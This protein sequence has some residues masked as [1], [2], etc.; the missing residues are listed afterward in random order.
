[1]SPRKPRQGGRGCCPP[2]AA[3]CPYLPVLPVAEYPVPIGRVDLHRGLAD[4][5]D[6]ALLVLAA[7]RPHPA[8]HLG[9][10]KVGRGRDRARWGTQ[11]GIGNREGMEIG[12][13][14]DREPGEG[15]REGVRGEGRTGNMEMGIGGDG[16]G[17]GGGNWGQGGDVGGN[18]G[19]PGGILG[20]LG[21]NRGVPGGGFRAPSP[22]PSSLP[23]P[24]PIPPTPHP[25]PLH[26]PP[27]DPW[28]RGLAA[29]S[30]PA[31]A[32]SWPYWEKE[33]GVR[34]GPGGVRT[35]PNRAGTRG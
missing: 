1:M 30:A 9:E 13:R 11:R 32:A 14:M 25:T 8:V 4:H 26:S 24:P 6:A 35:T 7:E 21:G 33:R 34:G 10:E 27:R 3:P 19:V 18:Q 22:A 2:P 31:S 28:A 17:T 16:P 29:S 5:L 15:A 23:P 12:G 20:G